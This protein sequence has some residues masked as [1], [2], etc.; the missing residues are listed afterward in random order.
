MLIYGDSLNMRLLSWAAF[1]CAFKFQ[2]GEN[3]DGWCFFSSPTW[4]EVLK[5]NLSLL[6]QKGHSVKSAN[7]KTTLT[8]K[9]KY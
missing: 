1:F 3:R 9:K 5:K 7:W 4:E 2:Q 8:F 6:G